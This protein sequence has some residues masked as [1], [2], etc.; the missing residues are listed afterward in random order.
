ME[1]VGGNELPHVNTML[2]SGV[3]EGEKCSIGDGGRSFRLYAN[4]LE[5][6]RSPRCD[7]LENHV[8][9]LAHTP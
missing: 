7:Q 1:R 5:R 2:I 6:R 8:V 9:R 3:F 4:G